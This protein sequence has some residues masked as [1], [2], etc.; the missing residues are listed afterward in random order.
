MGYVAVF[1]QLWD[2]LIFI[3]GVVS[4][5][6]NH[7]RTISQPWF[8]IAEHNHVPIILQ[9]LG[10]RL[11]TICIWPDFTCMVYLRLFIYLHLMAMFRWM[12]ANICWYSIR[13]AFGFD[14][15]LPRETTFL[16]FCSRCSFFLTVLYN[17]Y[18]L[19]SQVSLIYFDI[20]ILILI[21]YIYI[22]NQ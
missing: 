1:I 21:I 7:L 5:S 11:P 18:F 16:I 4:R 2:L 15:H 14:S 8:S 10:N 22:K 20:L 3:G 9:A 19:F 6:T 12:L 17:P 13:S